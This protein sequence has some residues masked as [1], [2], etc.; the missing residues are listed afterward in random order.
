M[1]KPVGQH[2]P[3]ISEE[4]SDYLRKKGKKQDDLK[5]GNNT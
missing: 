5:E 1:G 3:A 4:E 2:K